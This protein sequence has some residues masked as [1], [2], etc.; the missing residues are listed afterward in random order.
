MEQPVKEYMLTTID[1]PWNPFTHFDEW[2]KTDLI[3]GYNTLG[4]VARIAKTSSNMDNET[5]LNCINNA[6]EEI[7]TL[8]PVNI[9]YRVT[10]DTDTNKMYNNYLKELNKE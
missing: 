1:N 3:K 6:I 10:K 7:L 9:Y 8:N 4:Y 2:Y 5:Y